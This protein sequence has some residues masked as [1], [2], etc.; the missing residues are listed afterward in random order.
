M[1]LNLGTAIAYVELDLT[2]FN[3]GIEAVNSSLSRMKQEAEAGGTSLSTSLTTIGSVAENVGSS[4]TRTLT[5]PIA[6]FMDSSLE[7]GMSFEAM[8]SK[9][10]A[11][12]DD[13][14]ADF[15]A[16]AQKLEAL[17]VQLGAQTKFT[18]TEAAQAMVYM[19]MAGW[20]TE[21]I[22]AGLPGVMDLAAASG[23]DLGTV[24][25]I[26]TDS[27][28]AFGM[29][30]DE[31]GRYADIL[32]QAARRSNTD[33]AKMGETFKYVAPIAGAMGYS[34]EDTAVAIG[35]MANQGIKAS[36]AGTTLRGAI[37]RLASPTD[38]MVGLMVSLGLATEETAMVMD[39]GALQKAMSKVQTKT[40]DVEAAQ[41]KY[42]EAVARYGPE[43]TQAEAAM[44]KVEK[45]QI[46]LADASRELEAAQQGEIQTVGIKNKLMVDEYGNAKSLDEV[47]TVLRET[48]KGLSEEEQIQAATLLF[49]KTAMSGMLAVIRSSD[50]DFNGLKED[51]GDATG[52]AHE[53]ADE[54]MNNLQGAVTLLQSAIESLQIKIYN[55]GSGALTDLVNKVREVVEWFVSLDDETLQQIV[56]FGLMVAAV[57]P[58]LMIF[59]KLT[60]FVG[61]T[62]QTFNLLKSVFSGASAAASTVTS[63]MSGVTT[64]TGLATNS[65]NILTTT[66]HAFSLKGGIITGVI[67][68]IVAGFIDAWKT[69]AEFRESFESLGKTLLDFIGKIGELF[70]SVW[71]AI[72]PAIDMLIELMSELLQMILPPLIKV[73]EE[74]MKALS[75]LFPIFEFL[76]ELIS[77]IAKILFTVLKPVLEVVGAILGATCEAIATLLGWINDL[78]EWL[79]KMFQPLIDFMDGVKKKLNDW[80][81]WFESD[82]KDSGKKAVEGFT[83]GLEGAAPRGL[84][85]V[86][87]FGKGLAKS[88]KDT[89][90]IHSPSGVFKDFA[91]NMVDGVIVG[92]SEKSVEATNV[93]GKFAN[94]MF[95]N[96]INVSKNVMDGLR[97]T[98]WNAFQ[99]VFMYLYQTGSDLTS[100]GSSMFSGFFSSIQSVWGNITS[101]VG[102]AVNNLLNTVKN[103][104][105]W[106]S[107]WS[108]SHANGLDYVPYDGYVAQLHQG[109]RVLTK[110]EAKE[111]DKGGNQKG[112]DTF[113]F[114]NTKP[115]PYEYARQMKRA[116]REL[117]F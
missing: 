116:K 46:A 74:F 19:G 12:T 48:F 35:L 33:V 73:V 65:T 81:G 52:A 114:Y 31:S 84:S 69:S 108:G 15:E 24:S 20:D 6:S 41:V 5:L 60:T 22:I 89:L 96:F 110:A 38:D 40:L 55:L 99:P 103:A 57:G 66:M 90:D 44:I 54:M 113:N 10:R 61:Q 117:A 100:V 82:M 97:N 16:R 109:E 80:F 63:A 101:W 18:A 53:M 79:K 67:A 37:S 49:G 62:M 23:E 30:A 26:V 2:A 78:I 98:I 58:L 85:A 1:A 27:L 21:Q 72:K 17:A 13:G 102:N 59:G 42:N 105:N 70:M 39:E 3:S 68:L 92:T 28:T 8:M 64:A 75:N 94:D 86:E 50:S 36:Q 76:A 88:F 51:M 25:D 45:A 32:A 43:S 112:G 9:V 14:E 87:S 4:L 71:N 107:S 91:H 77:T 111:Y 56:S 29:S 47:I 7:A 93:M 106:V 104:L 11:I 34:A 95:S 115:D 83:F